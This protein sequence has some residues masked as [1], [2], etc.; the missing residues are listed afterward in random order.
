M[1]SIET[2]DTHRTICGLRKARADQHR[3]SG[4]CG[5]LVLIESELMI[6][7][8][9]KQKKKMIQLFKSLVINFGSKCVNK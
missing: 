5:M 9:K 7:K 4:V 1:Q 8:N 2:T 3:C 6:Y